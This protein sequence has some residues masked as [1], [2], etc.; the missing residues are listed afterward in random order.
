MTVHA[1][2]SPE[3]LVTTCPQ[4][5]GHSAAGAKLPAA[6]AESSDD[7]I[8]GMTLDGDI[9]TWNSSAERP[10]G[11]R[12]E[13]MIGHSVA[14]LK[15][16][17]LPGELDEILKQVRVGKRVDHYET[18][19]RRKD[20]ATITVSLTVSPVRDA[21]GTVVGAS[22]R[23]RAHRPTRVARDRTAYAR[24]TLNLLDSVAQER[25]QLK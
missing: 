24:A 14:L 21:S 4:R 1:G 5:P 6:S 8:I 23:A 10:Y 20:G 16:A 2:D 18:R 11:S 9:T 13:E 22:A 12:A 25:Q 19:R 3:K 15:P 17:G 7:A